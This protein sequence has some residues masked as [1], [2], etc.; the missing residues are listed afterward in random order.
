MSLRKIKQVILDMDGVVWHGDT[1]LPDLPRFFERLDALGISYVFATN[2]A[3]KTRSQYIE[4]FGRFGVTITGDQ[5]MTSAIATGMYL[6]AEY[7]PAATAAYVVGKDGIRESLA[8]HGFTV[9]E[10]LDET[11]PAQLVVVGFNPEVRYAD[12]AAATIQV[13]KH[14]ARFIATNPDTT[15]PSERGLLPGA[16]SL[17]AFMR[18]STGTEPTIIGKPYP[19]M[20]EQALI[21]LGESATPDNT[22]MVGDRL[23]TDIEGGNG[24]GLMTGLVRTGVSRDA[25]LDESEVKPDYVFDNIHAL[26][27]RLEEAHG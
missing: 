2:N 19:T 23:N 25:N 15:F 14:G 18:A 17:V 24:I 26:V 6:A 4:K 16:G 27:T 12:F 13:R 21:L 1:P 5:V 10:D 20:F 8:D 7:E 22:L 9:L 3:S 11:T